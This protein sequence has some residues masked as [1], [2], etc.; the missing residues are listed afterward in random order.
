[1]FKQVTVVFETRDRGQALALASK[2]PGFKPDAARV[3]FVDDSGF[4]GVGG[5]AN[6]PIAKASPVLAVHESC[7]TDDCC[8][9]CT[10]FETRTGMT[11]RD[12]IAD[13][14]RR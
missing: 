11:L 14:D 10:S 6:L 7:G 5:I 1:M 4:L 9:R 2:I 8:R 12:P 3:G 13:P